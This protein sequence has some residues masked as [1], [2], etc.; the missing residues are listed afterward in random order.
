MQGKGSAICGTFTTLARDKY[1]TT[2]TAGHA[3]SRVSGF[4]FQISGSCRGNPETRN[5][6]PKIR[7]CVSG[8]PGSGFGFQ[9]PSF[10]FR[11]SGFG[12]RAPGFGF[13]VSDFRFRVS[14]SG[15]RVPGFG[16]RVSGSGFRVTEFGPV[17]ASDEREVHD[18]NP[19]G[20]QLPSRLRT[21]VELSTFGGIVNF[22]WKVELSSFS[23]PRGC[24]RSC[25]RIVNFRCYV[26][27]WPSV[28]E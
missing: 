15:F 5:P 24:A 1:H 3:R 12:I 27:V 17:E 6:E 10:G 26:V 20:V 22:R 21:K 18:A 14:S 19:R 28:F 9:V 7:N 4:G 16:F 13:R 25:A 2:F 8:F 11:V 23:S